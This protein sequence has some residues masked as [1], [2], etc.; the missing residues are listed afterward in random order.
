MSTGPKERL[1]ATMRGLWLDYR[2]RL[3]ASPRFQRWAADFPL[4]RP[5]ARR[6]ARAVFDLCAGFVYSQILLACWQGGLLQRLARGPATVGELAAE[7]KLSELTMRRL[8]DAAV[9]LRLLELLPDDRVALGVHGAA[10]VANPGVGAMISHHPVFYRDLAEPLALLRESAPAANLGRFWSYAGASE[11]AALGFEAVAPYSALMT[12]SQS[13]LATD[14]L[15]AYPLHRHHC[16]LDVGGGEGE[17]IARAA[18]RYPHLRLLCFDL[19]AVAHRAEARW[20]EQGFGTRAQAVGGDFLRDELP[21]GAD[22]ICLI[23][24]LHDHDEAA[25]RLLLQRVRAALGPGGRLLVAEPLRDGGRD[26]PVSDAYFNFYLL[27]MGQGR[28]RSAAELGTLLQ[29]AGFTRVR[30]IRTRR[31]QQTGLLIAEAGAVVRGGYP[32]KVLR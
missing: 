25:A 7:A 8:I 9:S 29:R 31:P 24:V 23:R 12:A 13:L 16:L 21:T 28:P 20:R 4:T 11:P 15:D 18:A 6:R 32:Q 5:I 3:L 30:R 1:L 27:A 26:T 14:I 2:N 17:F 22:L 10:L 19:P